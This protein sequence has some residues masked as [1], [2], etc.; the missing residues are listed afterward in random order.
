V[1]CRHFNDLDAVLESDA[2]D[3]FRQLIF[4]L[5]PPPGLWPIG[6]MIVPA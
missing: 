1:V 4:A 2:S 5:E 6:K 3:N